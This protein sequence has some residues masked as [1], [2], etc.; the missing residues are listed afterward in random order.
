MRTPS[1]RWIECEN[2]PNEQ[3]KRSEKKESKRKRKQFKIK[4]KAKN[5][6]DYIKSTTKHKRV[7]MDFDWIIKGL[8]NS[9]NIAIVSNSIIKSQIRWVKITTSQHTTPRHTTPRHATKSIATSPNTAAYTFTFQKDHLFHRPKQVFLWVIYC[10]SFIPFT[11]IPASLLH[12]PSFI[13]LLVFFSFFL[14]RHHFHSFFISTVPFPLL[15]YI[16]IHLYM[17]IHT[18]II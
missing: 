9:I 3:K 10:Y 11:C 4:I 12:P 15:H 18:N 6:N 17:Y 5:N 8:L 7:K 13:Q 1:G 2:E 14:F 16:F